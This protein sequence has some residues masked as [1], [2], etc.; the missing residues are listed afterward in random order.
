MPRPI[1][2]ALLA[3]VSSAQAQS[4]KVLQ[5]FESD[6]DLRVWDFKQKSARL[7]P[8]HATSGSRSLRISADEYL[9]SFR[10]P[11]D[12]SG[13]DT[14]EIDAFVE[15]ADV[16]A[17]SV[18]VGDQAW[19]DKDRS[20]WNRHN[21]S[22]NLKP[23]PNVISIPVN[24]LYR[25]EAGSRNNDL[26][27]SIDPESIVRFDLGFKSRAGGGAIYLDRV[28]LV[29]ESRPD[30]ILAFDF[31]P[32]SQAVF[33][34]FTA[35]SSSTTFGRNGA[36]AGLRYDVGA[37]RARDDGFPTRLYQ[38]YAMLDD[39]VVALPDGEY[40]AWLV[41]D[42]LGYWGGEQAQHRTRS[43]EADGKTVWSE[44]RG[45]DGPADYLWRFE[46][47]EP[48]PDS[49]LWDLYVNGLFKPVRFNFT[50]RGGK[51]TLRF[52]S[53]HPFGTKVAAMVLHPRRIEADAE[54][55]I[56]GVEERNRKEF[57]DKA[58]FSGPRKPTQAPPDAR[59]LGYWLGVP[60]LD[61]DLNQLDAPGGAG[62]LRRLAAQG[63]RVSLTFA[64]RA[65]KQ[66]D[67]DAKLT[68]TDL[69]GPGLIPAANVDL[70]YVQHQAQRSFNSIAYT[71]SPLV[72][73]PIDGLKLDNL[74]RQF[75]LTVHVPRGTP[76]GG[77]IADAILTCGELKLSLP[78]KLDVLPFAL[79]EPDFLMGFYGTSVP[80]QILDRRGKDAWRDLF[81]R[82]KESGMNS[83]SG[84]PA[85][86]FSGLDPAG[87]PILDFSACDEFFALAREA[88]FGDQPINGYGGPAHVTGLHDGY[89]V[90]QTGREWERKTGRPIGE[91]IGLVHAAVR[92]HAAKNNWPKVQVSLIDEP[93]VIESA[94]A[95]LELHKLY[96]QHAPWVNIGGSYSV[97]WKDDP[98]E[99][100]VQEMF[101]T[102][103]WSAL[104]LHTETDLA[105]AREFGKDLLIY[106]QGRT[107]FS[108]GA[109]QWAEMHKGVK[110][111]LQWHL[112]AL[113]G[114][115]F[116]D[117]DGREPDTAMIHWGKGG[118]LPTIHLHRIRE[119]ADD[120]RYAATLWNLARTN[121]S[122]AAKESIAW[123]QQ[124]SQQ[125]PIGK[126]K[127]PADWMGEEA[128]RAEC[129]RRIQSLR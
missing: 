82:L 114:Y 78:L 49:K 18:L 27:T 25:G 43:I 117:L 14:L 63:Q 29:K 118:I 5:D 36:T 47:V 42:D 70:R 13:Y 97:H 102:V 2:L 103:N 99:N 126:N 74:T 24:G 60:G 57:E 88:G 54:K 72:L 38:D 44:D 83:F 59:D 45:E 20:Y 37:G 93:R 119:G 22:F 31:G 106:N 46:H 111:R 85:I 79:D 69:K 87:K 123:L 122:P 41:F 10:F 17:G 91:L 100:V 58:V 89:V 33:P 108:F 121:D 28:R 80:R 77:Y 23:G 71:I 26:K 51:T 125:I 75:W 129:I 113:H 62:E 56:A 35:I 21:S 112:L 16:V 109:Y 12:W 48:R 50:A 107:R 68:I 90:G 94:K 101:K 127:P 65:L 34:G 4:V 53:D 19:Q 3:L 11:K 120:F 116:F 55:W 110:G 39:F 124:I 64:I 30:G 7:S 9:N 52:K 6:A 104:N 95:Q 105:K 1:L 86:R 61:Q 98:F 40:G 15:S 115:Q 128:F 81:R 8:D 84:G 32:A 66:L 76:P 73:R 92:D 67:G 96:R